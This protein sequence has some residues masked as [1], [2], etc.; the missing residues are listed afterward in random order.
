M[1]TS[2]HEASHRIFQEHPEA[3]APVFEA[4]GLPP[5][6]KAIIEAMSPDATEIRPMERRVDTVLKVELSE[7]D[8]FMVAVEKQTDPVPGKG[9]SWA[10]YVAYLHAK[11]GLPVLLVAVCHSKRTAKWA[12]G[13]FESRVGPWATQV[14]RPFV[15]GPHNVPEITDVSMVTENPAL[16][17]I[18]AIVHCE[19]E[20]HPAILNM[21]AGGIRFFDKATAK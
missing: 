18:S 8:R 21:L 10:Y 3:L 11:F 19:S 16:A 14:T 6:A 5:P 13:P 7:G 1:V 2:T 4:L 20:N 12:T 17:T 15:L 9:I